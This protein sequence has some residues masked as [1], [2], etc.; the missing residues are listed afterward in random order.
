MRSR[1]YTLQPS[2]INTQIVSSSG[3]DFEGADDS[4]EE[5]GEEEE[6]GKMGSDDEMMGDEFPHDSD[7]DS[8]DKKEVTEINRSGY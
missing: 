8:V 7:E 5:E 4:G 6:G 2:T 1:W 3:D